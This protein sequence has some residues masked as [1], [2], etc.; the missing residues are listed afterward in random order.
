MLRPDC[1]RHICGLGPLHSNGG[2]VLSESGGQEKGAVGVGRV[3]EPESHL[4]WRCWM[5][6]SWKVG[7]ERVQCGQGR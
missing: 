4:E 6:A 1:C 5:D 7:V 3:Q 2:P